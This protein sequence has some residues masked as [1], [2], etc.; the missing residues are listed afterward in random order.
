M[1]VVKL[2]K[3]LVASGVALSALCL[4]VPTASA[5]Q[6]ASVLLSSKLLNTCSI[7]ALLPTM[8]TTTK[9]VYG[10]A[11]VKCTVASTIS[12]SMMVVEMDGSVIDSK[13]EL[14]E[15]KY[16][17]T[18]KANTDTTITTSTFVCVS[19]EL[20]NEELTTRAKVSPGG[21]TWSAYD[22]VTP[23]NNQYAC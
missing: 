21:T 11:K 6:S 5:T 10:S 19:T 2:R 9:V 22:T 7:T 17:I 1:I 23:S 3:G 16:T 18:V 15:K 8:N 13:V 14:A 12:V 4:A 20:D